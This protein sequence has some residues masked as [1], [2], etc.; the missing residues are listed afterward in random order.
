MDSGQEKWW[1]R[2]PHQEFNLASSP[3]TNDELRW[4][5]GWAWSGRFRLLMAGQYKY[6]GKRF[7]TGGTQVSNGWWRAISPDMRILN[8]QEQPHSP[9]WRSFTIFPS[10]LPFISHIFTIL[11]IDREKKAHKICLNVKGKNGF[12]FH[13]FLVSFFHFHF[14]SHFLQL[15]GFL[16]MCGS[17]VL[18]W[19]SFFV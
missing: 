1:G 7:W 18:N 19:P 12:P 11:A 6:G 4:A 15:L 8:G 10:V 2:F 9:C 16:K 17:N 3:R 5:N 14:Q 13:S